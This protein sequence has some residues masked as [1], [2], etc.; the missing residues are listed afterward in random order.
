MPFDSLLDLLVD[1]VAQPGLLQQ[2]R[3]ARL[4]PSFQSSPRSAPMKAIASRA[5]IVG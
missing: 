1:G 5:F 4:R 3:G 2:D